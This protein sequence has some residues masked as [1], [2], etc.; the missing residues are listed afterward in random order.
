MRLSAIL[1]TLPVACLLAQTPQSSQTTPLTILGPDG[2]PL[3]AAKQPTVTMSVDNLAGGGPDLLSLPADKVVITIGE[4]KITAGAL[5]AIID[6]FPP[7][8]RE[9]ARGQRRREFVE[10]YL[11]KVKLLAADARRQKLDQSPTFQAQAAYTADNMLAGA[12]FQNLLNT[13]PVDEKT[14][15]AWYEQHKGDWERIRARHIL[16]RAA[17]SPVPLR[18]ERKEL[19]DTEAL[20]KAQEIR[21]KLEGGADF[22]ALAKADSDDAGSGAQG[23]DLGYF[24]RGQMVPTFYE[25]AAALQP[26]QLSQPI[27]TPYGY[28]VIKVEARDAKPFEEV[29]ADVE[30]RLRNELAQQNLEERRKNTQVILDP[31]VFP[32]K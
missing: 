5:R 17:G 1:L 3:P 27:R 16:I 32:G 2:K 8:L 12:M 30:K 28:H 22:A 13:L 18:P 26:G 11:V 21:K 20:A 31:D 24:S 7:N 9:A 25:A 6:T 23:G 14:A 19:S 29:R 15:R 10:N 4:E